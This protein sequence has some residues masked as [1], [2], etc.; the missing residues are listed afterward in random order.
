M[1]SSSGSQEPSPPAEDTGELL[2][3]QAAALER[4]ALVSDPEYVPRARAL[5]RLAG[6]VV[7]LSGGVLAA[8]EFAL[9]IYESHVRRTTVAN[10][11]EAAREMYEVEGS[12]SEASSM[13]ERAQE[14][15]PQDVNVVRLAAYIDGMRAVERLM[16]LDRPFGKDDVEEYGRA[17]GQAVMLQRVD[18]RSPEWAILRG[19]LAL[20]V[21]EAERARGFLEQALTIEPG[22]SFATLRL[23]LVHRALAVKAE[24]PEVR[25]RELAA[26]LKLIERTLA[27]SPTFKWAHLWKGAVALE[28]SGDADTAMKSF[29]DAIAI[30]PRFVTAWVNLGKAAESKGDLPEAERAYVRALEIR[31]DL[32]MAITGLA[33]VYGL[34]DKYEI[35]LRYARRA[36]DA[37]AG[38]L[39]AWVMRG[40]LALELAKESADDAAAHDALIE[41]A[42]TC[43]STALDLDPRQG[44]AYIERSKLN[45]Q[46]RRLREAGGDARNAILFNPRDPYAWNVLGEYLLEI[47]F[48]D[49]AAA[50]F[51]KALELDPAFD[52]GLLGRAKSLEAAGKLE[53]A[54]ADL[55]A[56]MALVSDDLKALALLQRG[57]VREARG[58][59]EGALADYAA[60]RTGDPEY[61]DAWLSEARSL[62]AAGRTEE[63]RAA[64]RRALQLR[65]SDETA[66]ALAGQ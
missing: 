57:R 31:P 7:A 18:A 43:Y 35:G 11:V 32:A 17:M 45:R 5:K 28:Q 23:A 12:P 38:S 19:Q 46:A 24:D 22:N 59:N 66:K 20:A 16:N 58:N 3:R 42:I 14:L 56:V 8:Y 33:Y 52:A 60:A 1:M 29:Q 41:E 39:E 34:Q 25:A 55:D 64:A 40:R 6:L 30:D 36:T 27:L 15:G 54:E 62:C 2:R 47:D 44:D 4:L 65:P 48:H 49:E 26:C 61:F 53:E 9:F 50:A 21:G 63:C 37:N 10:W 51:S 13:L